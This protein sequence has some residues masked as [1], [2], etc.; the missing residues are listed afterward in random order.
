MTVKAKANSKVQD[1][2]ILITTAVMS[3]NLADSIENKDEI[4]YTTNHVIAGTGLEANPLFGANLLPNSLLG[5]LALIL[6]ILALII[7]G[8][9]LYINY[10]AKNSRSANA[11]QIDNLPM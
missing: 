6:V 9:K 2:D 8:R 11:N 1:S 5:W 3:Y 7:I 4:A 10:L